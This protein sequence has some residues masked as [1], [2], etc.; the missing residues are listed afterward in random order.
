MAAATFGAPLKLCS[1]ASDF[2]QGAEHQG[3]SQPMN[4]WPSST[5]VLL[6]SQSK[7]MQPHLP[8]A[9]GLAL[10]AAPT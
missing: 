5:V 8:L 7:L 4:S 2:S 3:T 1:L 6:A 9:P 10:P